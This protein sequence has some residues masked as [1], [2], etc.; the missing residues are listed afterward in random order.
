MFGMK[1]E[2]EVVMEGFINVDLLCCI[3]VYYYCYYVYYLFYEYEYICL[4]Y[5]IYFCILLCFNGLVLVCN[6]EIDEKDYYC[7]LEVFSNILLWLVIIFFNVGLIWI[8]YD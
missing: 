6:N 4:G 8:L 3:E 2:K 1:D 7:Y 5:L